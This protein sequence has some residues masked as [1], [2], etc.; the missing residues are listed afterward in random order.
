METRLIQ[1]V[2]INTA[3]M[4]FSKDKYK[5]SGIDD[6]QSLNIYNPSSGIQE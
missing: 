4:L 1:S 6:N 3:N 2:C 5:T